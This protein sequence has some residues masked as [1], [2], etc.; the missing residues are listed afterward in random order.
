MKQPRMV[1]VLM[2]RTLVL[3]NQ[4]ATFFAYLFTE[5]LVGEQVHGL[6]E[7]DKRLFDSL[8]KKYH[9]EN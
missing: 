4:S 2:L 5:K 8:T 6:G 1:A 7:F 9:I 3:Q